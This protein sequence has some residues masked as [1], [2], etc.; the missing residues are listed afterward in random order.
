M[1][2]PSKSSPPPSPPT[3]PRTKRGL[4]LKYPP[5]KAPLPKRR[6]GV[7]LRASRPGHLANWRVFKLVI[8]SPLWGVS[9]LTTGAEGALPGVLPFESPGSSR[10]ALGRPL[11][12]RLRLTLLSI[13]RPPRQTGQLPRRANWRPRPP[14]PTRRPRPAPLLGPRRATGGP[15]APGPEDQGPPVARGGVGNGAPGYPTARVTLPGPQP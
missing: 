5:S 13:L 12:A 3:A 2:P 9:S 1:P 8:L 14:R 6:E 15:L 11:R 4:C 10:L 7:P